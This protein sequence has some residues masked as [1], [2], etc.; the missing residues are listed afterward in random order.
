MKEQGILKPGEVRGMRQGSV[1][2]SRQEGPWTLEMVKQSSDA[3]D[4]YELQSAFV[5]QDQ[6]SQ[7]QHRP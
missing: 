7:R 1:Y 4:G 5:V 6:F 2:G 3:V